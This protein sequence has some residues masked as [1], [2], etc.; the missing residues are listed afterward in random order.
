MTTSETIIK[1]LFP[2]T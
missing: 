2:A 1:R